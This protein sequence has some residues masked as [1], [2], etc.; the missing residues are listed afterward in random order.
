[1]FRCHSHLYLVTHR[2]GQHHIFV[3]IT[4]VPVPCTLIVYVLILMISPF[5]CRSR[6]CIPSTVFEASCQFGVSTAHAQNNDGQRFSDSCPVSGTEAPDLYFAFSGCFSLHACSCTLVCACAHVD[7][8]ALA[9]AR[10]CVSIGGRVLEVSGNFF[11]VMS[12]GSRARAFAAPH[13]S[14]TISGT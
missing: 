7:S 10:V 12:N 1:M 6:C 5:P 9:H 14:C 3:Q 4:F 11:L 8:C 2:L 13:Q